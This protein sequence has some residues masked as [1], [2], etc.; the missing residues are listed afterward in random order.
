MPSWLKDLLEWA[1]IRVVL[2]LL[3]VAAA[4]TIVWAWLLPILER[5]PTP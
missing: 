4:V 3:A 1:T 2:V 5:P